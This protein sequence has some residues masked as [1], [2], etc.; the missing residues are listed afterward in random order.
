MRVNVKPDKGV[1]EY[2]VR[3]EPQM[4]SKDFRFKL[5]NQHQS[6]LGP[7]KTFDGVTLYLPFTLPSQ[8]SYTFI[9]MN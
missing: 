3:F 5:L 2:E 6:T 4:D 9:H 1:F 8:V 7:A